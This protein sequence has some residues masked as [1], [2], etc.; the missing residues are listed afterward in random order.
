MKSRPRD[1]YTS[2]EDMACV[3]NDDAWLGDR[4][5]RKGWLDVIRVGVYDHDVRLATEATQGC[6]TL[7]MPAKAAIEAYR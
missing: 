4:G 7:E 5:E 2:P 1:R 3:I 6:R